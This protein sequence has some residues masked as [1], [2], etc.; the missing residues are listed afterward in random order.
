MMELKVLSFFSLTKEKENNSMETMISLKIDKPHKLFQVNGKDT[1]TAY[2]TENG[3][4]KQICCTTEQN[5]EHRIVTVYQEKWLDKTKTFSLL[6]DYLKYYVEHSQA[7]TPPNLKKQ[8]YVV[9]NVFS[10]DSIL[11]NER[12]LSGY[13]LEEIDDEFVSLYFEI[14]NSLYE[15]KQFLFIAS[16]FLFVMDMYKAIYN[17]NFRTLSRNINIRQR[18]AIRTYSPSDWERRAIRDCI[19]N[20]SEVPPRYNL[21]FLILMER[22][23]KVCDL[24]EYTE[25]DL[26]GLSEESISYY[27]NFVK[28]TLESEYL[29]M[30]DGKF[31]HDRTFGTELR[32]FV[33]NM[34]FPTKVTLKSLYYDKADKNELGKFATRSLNQSDRYHRIV[35]YYELS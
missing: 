4:K 6:I 35:A 28:D 16:Y 9:K 30:K 26:E 32:I 24:I 10:N 19:F 8:K 29:F 11:I 34:C 2:Y 15:P 27:Q 25:K 33:K 14:L 23:I 13:R 18:E 21:A 12:P 17:P 3:K 5:L 7:D 22:K 31:L 1:W 20:D